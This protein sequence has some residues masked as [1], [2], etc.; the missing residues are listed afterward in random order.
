M[1]L[2]IIVFTVKFKLPNAV[3]GA[4]TILRRVGKGVCHGKQ[5]SNNEVYVAIDD[6]SMIA[7][8]PVHKYEIEK[9]TFAALNLDCIM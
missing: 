2:L 4:A 8:H 1:H 9:G 6:I 3:T 5:L 7:E